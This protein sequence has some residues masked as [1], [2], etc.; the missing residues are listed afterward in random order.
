MADHALTLFEHRLAAGETVSLPAGNRVLY[1]VEGA[2]KVAGAD[3]A[4]GLATN[5]AWCA[6]RR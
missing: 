3:T 1:V 2:A 4:A 6:R 5:S